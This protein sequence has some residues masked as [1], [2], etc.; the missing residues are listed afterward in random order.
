[1]KEKNNGIELPEKYRF[2]SDLLEGYYSSMGI[3]KID[4]KDAEPYVVDKEHPLA[5]FIDFYFTLIDG[6]TKIRYNAYQESSGKFL[7][8]IGL[9][10]S[11]SEE[12]KIGYEK[13]KAGL[14]GSIE[15]FKLYKA[16][17]EKTKKATID[18]GLPE[19]DWPVSGLT[20]TIEQIDEDLKKIEKDIETTVTR[21]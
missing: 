4:H 9:D 7:E 14:S 11:E 15:R 5:G 13:Y 6:L 20:Y 21:M 3:P 2:N 12:E 17:V 1:M 18:A 19:G 10:V 8:Q 16:E